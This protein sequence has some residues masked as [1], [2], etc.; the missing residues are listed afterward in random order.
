MVCLVGYNLIF[1]SLALPVNTIIIIKELTME[2]FQVMKH[3]AGS[4]T[5]DVSLGLTDIADA[6]VTLSFFL[7]PFN[8]ATFI[9]QLIMGRINFGE[10]AAENPGENEDE[11]YKIKNFD[12]N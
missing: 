4:E 9:W 1:D 12:G 7:N 10:I 6:L 5:D 11:Y 2:F 8:I 3:N